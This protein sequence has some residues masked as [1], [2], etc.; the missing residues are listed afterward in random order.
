MKTGLTIAI[1]IF[2]LLFA[3]LL[4]GPSF[5]DWNKYKTQILE[6]AK[7]A[8]GYN[9]HIDGD[10]GL[11]VLPTPRLKIQDL[12]VDAPRGSADKL[13]SVDEA[14]VSVKLTSLI[15]GNIIVDTVRLEKPVI[16]LE[17]LANGENSWAVQQ[18][19][20]ADE[21]TGDAGA[22]KS[23]TDRP[24]SLGKVVVNEGQLTY[25]D[26]KTGKVQD[27]KDVNL[28][29]SA[30]T[31]QGPFSVDGELLYNGKRI[32]ITA[33]TDAPKGDKKEFDADVELTLP[34]ADAKA[35]FK[36]VI[37]LAPMEVQGKLDVRAKNLGAALAATDE[38]PSAALARPL[39]FSGLVTANENRLQSED[40]DIEYGD[41]KGTGNLTVSGLKDQNPVTVD[42]N[43]GFS[44]ILNFDQ[45]APKA[46]KSKEKS[47]EE[48]VAKGE[49]LK[50]SSGSGFLPESLSLPFPLEAKIKVMADGIQTGGQV[51][52]GVNADIAKTGGVINVTAKISDMPGKTNADARINLTYATS[53]KSGEKGV[54]YADP[55]MTFAVNGLSQQ[56]PTL[57]R[58]FAPDQDANKALEIY[59]EARF[60]LK[61]NIGSEKV[62]L[63]GSTL[64]LD[65][66]N[67]ALAGSYAP[68]GN[69]GRPD[70]VIDL[71]TD[72]IDIDHI[73]SRMN[74]QKKQAVQ[75]DTA[76]KPDLKK[77]LEPVRGFEMPY[78]LTFDLSAQKAKFSGQDINGVRIKGRAAGTS[79]RLDV[80]SA[81]DYMGAAASLKGEVADLKTLSG[82]DMSFYGKTSNLKSLM[83]SFKMDTSKL[84]DSISGAE[85]NITA[86]GK[87]EDLSFKADI[88]ALSGK[89][90]ASGTMTGLLDKP[91]FNNLSVGA[92]HPNL[93][94]AVQIFNPSFS[95]GAG[96]EKP[97]DFQA[98]AV[99]NGNVYDLTGMQATLGSATFS[100]DL[101]VDQSGSKTAIRGTLNAGDIPLDSLLGAKKGGSS[102]ASSGGGSSGASS[103]GKWS[104]TPLETGW[105]HTINMDL[106]LSAKSITYGGWDFVSPSTK[107]NL[108]DGTL[109][110]DGL[111]AGLFGGNAALDAR[112]V[113]PADEKQPLS[114]AI[115]TKM[116]KVD[117][118]P[119]AAALSGS[120]RIKATGDVT[121][122]LDV[123]GSGLSSHALVSSL[124]GKSS[125][126]GNTIVMKGFDLAQ[127]GLALVD[128]GKPLDRLGGIV[129]GATSSGE[130]RFDT[131]KGSYDI[132]Q[133]VAT[134]SS[135]EMDGPAANI[136]SRGNV[137]LP[138]WYIDTVHTIT[139]KNAKET[140]TFDVNIK[141]PLDSPANTFGKGLFNDV[142]TRRLQQKA[143]EKLPDVLGKDLTGK[144]QG[145]G[146]LPPAQ[147]K[148]PAVP[149]EEAPATTPD[150]AA[151]APAPQPVAPA[152]EPAPQ[153]QSQ[154]QDPQK[155]LE[156]EAGKA[157]QG[158]LNGL[159]Q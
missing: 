123:S 112:V 55:S 135:M 127:I 18:S 32:G 69:G 68:H 72:T 111:K 95:G 17:T 82:I 130:T 128:T 2:G 89:L 51:F 85:A 11:S 1:T 24:L 145:L 71:T 103:G 157:I 94:K 155:A 29:M 126:N 59:K 65:D 150:A 53:S 102:G 81:Q 62:T 19:G 116:D 67:L 74:G 21:P 35:G 108:K 117:V 10:I 118:E 79:L 78:N 23:D 43:M 148:Q 37:A 98:K 106:S 133:G 87:A 140:G 31:L 159:L 110:V 46:D 27:L 42:G 105:M 97:F 61:G 153:P 66:T 93:V 154:Q 96:L 86:I 143:V 129:S 91:S 70:I 151:P 109:V 124:Q 38:K 122:D 88:A 34:D 136:K 47:V 156:E 119:L 40:I 7:S 146:I 63:S 125:L 14:Y 20:G 15:S 25:K 54:T 28:S 115:K 113:D 107:I 100:G 83:N 134:I 144:L 26:A 121:L 77:S 73:Q 131:V 141:G 5:M 30:K 36:G 149:V 147:Q 142:L 75:K 22:K 101:T 12:S 104:K 56:L 41:T 13:V 57:L 9:I 137:N 132:M 64:Q 114:V 33:D 39:S 52:K 8:S 138:Q 92:N 45:I 152:P 48:R 139:F 60:D 90:R 80:A 58:S 3:A 16:A 99:K 158:V 4:I 50:S 84:P 44:G 6:Q 49:K 120:R 76:A